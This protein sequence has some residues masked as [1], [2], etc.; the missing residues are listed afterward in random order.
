MRTVCSTA[1]LGCLVDL[2]VLDDE[3][4]GIKTLGIC[5][6]LRV[7]QETEEEFGG[8][9]GPSSARDTELLSYDIL[10]TLIPFPNF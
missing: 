9:D 8:L 5:V 1:L 4:S 2:D 6:C 10:S 3:V 7:L